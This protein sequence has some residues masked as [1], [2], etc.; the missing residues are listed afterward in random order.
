MGWVKEIYFG[1]SFTFQSIFSSTFL[2]SS[3]CVERSICL[4][5]AR[6]PFAELL[7]TRREM[8][9]G[10]TLLPSALNATAQA[11]LQQHTDLPWSN[12]K[13]KRQLN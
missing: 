8:E 7:S 6:V 4:I 1:I 13:E 10:C 11:F 5:T 2:L 3:L 12:D 9:L